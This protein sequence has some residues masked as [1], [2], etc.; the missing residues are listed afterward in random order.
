VLALLA[1]KVSFFKVSRVLS[2]KRSL[3]KLNVRSYMKYTR[4]LMISD[5]EKISYTNNATHI[6]L[7]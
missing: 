7:C 6:L 2:P 3:L 1:E 5:K 4:V